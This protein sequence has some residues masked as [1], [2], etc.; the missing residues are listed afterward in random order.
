MATS[1]SLNERLNL[2]TT[3]GHLR[4]LPRATPLVDFCSNDYLGFSTYGLTGNV[5]IQPGAQRVRFG[6]TGSRLISGNSEAVEELEEIAR[7]RH[8]AEAALVFNSGYDANLGL[9][10]S[11]PSDAVQ[12]F[13]DEHAHAS[14]KDG[15]VLS[16]ALSQPF[17]HNDLNHLEV[18]LKSAKKETYVCVEAL[19]SM[20]G[21]FAPLVEM[22]NLCQRYGAHLIVDEAHSA[23][24]YGDAGAGLVQEL[25]L[26]KVVWARI[27]TYGKAFGCHGACVLGS[28]LLK[29]YLINFAHSFIY[30]TALP[31]TTVQATISAYELLLSSA[32]RCLLD[33]N[34]E[35]FCQEIAPK[36]RSSILLS[37]RS[38]IQCLILPGSKAMMASKFLAEQ[39]FDVKAIR[40][41]TVKRGTE[42]LRICLHSFNTAASIKDLV[43][44]MAS[45]V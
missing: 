34:I 40:S 35:I 7:V 39:G 16:K 15:V 3:R 29:K 11:L 33:G 42:R 10:S 4:S 31:S 23:G 22:A 17:R 38:A 27:V 2:A 5:A 8:R 1:Q 9:I 13:Y 41:P 32:A 28:P 36:L 37:S 12:I 30:S 18:R 14:I 44:G 25:G 24:I 19:Y 26:E 43:G 45:F 20:D 6:S 21:Q